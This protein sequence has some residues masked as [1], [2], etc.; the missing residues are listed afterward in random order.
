MQEE[1]KGTLHCSQGGNNVYNIVYSLQSSSK[2]THDSKGG[3]GIYLVRLCLNVLQN[4]V[5]MSKAL[6][7]KWSLETFEDYCLIANT[8]MFSVSIVLEMDLSMDVR[9]KH[10]QSN[11]RL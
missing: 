5:H 1:K 7:P 10:C 9:E 8:P 2:D 3:Y 6:S 11:T 4:I